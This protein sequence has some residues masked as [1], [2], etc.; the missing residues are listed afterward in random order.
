MAAKVLWRM[1][2]RTGKVGRPDERDDAGCDLSVLVSFCGF[3]KAGQSS[4]QGKRRLTGAWRRKHETTQD[5]GFT[6]RP[7]QSEQHLGQAEVV[8]CKGNSVVSGVREFGRSG[9]I[10]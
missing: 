10:M 1:C 6:T 3:Y 4:L 7:W 5:V 2:L 8:Q 9:P